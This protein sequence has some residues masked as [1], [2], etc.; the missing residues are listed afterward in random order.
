[1]IVHDNSLEKYAKLGY[2]DMPPGDNY[3]EKSIEDARK[4]TLAKLFPSLT[5]QEL[6]QKL[7]QELSESKKAHDY[8]PGGTPIIITPES[9]RLCAEALLR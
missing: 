6:E 1:M 9:R 8:N 5:E 2:F 4:Q 7:E 3:D